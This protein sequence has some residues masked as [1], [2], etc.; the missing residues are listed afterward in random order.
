[1]Y[2]DSPPTLWMLS[3]VAELQLFRQEVWEREVGF[4][5]EHGH[6]GGVTVVLVLLD[7]VANGSEEM[8]VESSEE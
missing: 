2:C 6:M 7:L 1:M 3:S 8:L 4:A 5:G